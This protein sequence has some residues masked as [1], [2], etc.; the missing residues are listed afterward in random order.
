MTIELAAIQ[1]ALAELL[2][3]PSAL[4]ADPAATSRASAI[5]SGNARLSP[6]EQVDIYREQFF[7][8]HVDSLREDFRSIEHRI[9][10]EAFEELV[11][12]Y[13]D[14]HPPS[15]FT[16]RDLGAEMAA[17]LATRS[18]WS[19]DRL[20]VDLARV[21]WA[22]V[23]AFDAADAP[24]F[25]PT[26]LAGVPEEAWPDARISLDPSVQ[27]LALGTAAHEYRNA[28]RALDPHVCDRSASDESGVAPPAE[29]DCFVV[30]Y[31]GPERLHYAEIDAEAF[32]LLG[33][34]VQ[35][36]R[37]ALACERA[38]ASSEVDLESFQGKLAIWFQEWTAKGWIRRVAF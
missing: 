14:A 10:D 33:E 7:L 17:F 12:A 3:R 6:V 28:V 25:D 27:R 31:R 30:V 29:R 11:R 8:R 34:L 18:P 15:S 4:V 1:S 19:D 24:P 35:G 2:R 21:E 37:L 36:V 32:T 23:D 26:S 16:L 22:F 20:L 9:G 5:A 38:A 13:L